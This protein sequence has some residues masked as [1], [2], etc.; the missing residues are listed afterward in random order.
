MELRI[1]FFK[2]RI[3]FQVIVQ[4]ITGC[5]FDREDVDSPLAEAFRKKRIFE[6]IFITIQRKDG[7]QSV[8]AQSSWILGPETVHRQ[9]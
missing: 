7:N 2:I 1:T 9:G 6:I 8:P 4:I 5:V 3:G